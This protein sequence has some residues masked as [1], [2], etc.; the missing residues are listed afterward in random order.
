[1]YIR[2]ICKRDC[3]YIYSY[4]HWS[5]ERECYYIDLSIGHTANHSGF[6]Y[7]TFFFLAVSFC[8]RMVFTGIHYVYVCLFKCYSRLSDFFICHKSNTTNFF[9]TVSKLLSIS[10]CELKIRF[11]LGRSNVSSFQIYSYM[12]VYSLTVILF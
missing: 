4:F 9:K 7:Y 3:Y 11:S 6:S 10:Y 12:H 8:T 1:M 2:Y 5:C